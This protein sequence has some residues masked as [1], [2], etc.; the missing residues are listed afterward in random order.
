MTISSFPW[1]DFDHKNIFLHDTRLISSL[2]T[3]LK[4]KIKDIL[5]EKHID[6]H[7]TQT[8]WASRMSWVK[9]VILT[10]WVIPV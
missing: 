5:E 9:F 1:P 10:H 6:L 2:V 4:F 8:S 3:L 7:Q